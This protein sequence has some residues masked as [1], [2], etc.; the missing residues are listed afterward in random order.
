V[1]AGIPDFAWINKNLPIADVARELDLR[2]GANGL[3]HCWHPDCHTNGDRTASVAIW[4]GHNTVK[5]FG[6]GCGVGPLGPINLVMD[7]LD[8][9]SPARAGVWIA[10]HFQVPTIPKKKHLTDS[11]RRIMRAGFEGERGLLIQSGL[12]SRLG[13]PAKAI[14]PVLRHFAERE[15][16]KVTF[17]VEI[18]YRAISRYSGVRS[19]NA[20]AKAIRELSEIHWLVQV[21]TPR[22]G[23]VQGVSVYLLT[24]Q[25]DALHE[26]ANALAQQMKDEISAERE[27]RQQQRVERSKSLKT[28]P[29]NRHA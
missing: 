19:H 22:E 27:L 21:P 25:S 23:A 14:A 2:F 7:V 6:N 3:I 8:F 20:I 29:A 24:P 16:G 18:S 5:C 28:I 13:L 10:K 11:P 1:S 4:Q 17:R 26:L 12:W 15:E 9:D